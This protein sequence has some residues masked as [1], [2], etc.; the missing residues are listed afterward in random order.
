M[1]S[2]PL[3]WPLLGCGCVWLL[4]VFVLFLLD[5]GWAQASHG[6]G[7]AFAGQWFCTGFP[8]SWSCLCWAVL[9]HRLPPIL[10]LSLLCFCHAQASPSRGI[11]FA[12]LW[13]WISFPW[14]WS[15][16][17][18]SVV[19]NRLSRVWV[20]NLLG[21][22]CAQAS[23]VFVLPLLGCCCAQASLRFWSCPCCSQNKGLTPEIHTVQFPWD[24]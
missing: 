20:I 14:P 10:V 3:A 17:C 5:C 1:H 4:P 16:H 9:V 19:V 2:L 22:S 12:G 11:A 18:W 7:L 24:Y 8:Q 6:L 15:C 21:S 13:L 23:P